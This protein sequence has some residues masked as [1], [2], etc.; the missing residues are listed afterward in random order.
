MNTINYRIEIPNSIVSKSF[1]IALVRK[2]DF[3]HNIRV[4]FKRELEEIFKEHG[5]YVDSLAELGYANFFKNNN[6]FFLLTNKSGSFYCLLLTI[7]L[8][9][10]QPC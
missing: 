1:R 2:G 3:F 6:F 7:V 5:L 8:F 4:V 9:N 10:R